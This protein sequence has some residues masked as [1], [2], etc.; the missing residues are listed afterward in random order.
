VRPIKP[1]TA[2]V[3]TTANAFSLPVRVYYEDT[4]SGGIVYYA[5]Y[6]KFM[7]RA[8]TEFLRELGFEQDHLRLHSKR[9]FVVKSA[10]VNY[11]QPAAFNALLEVTASVSDLR[12]ASVTFAQQIRLMQQAPQ[13]IEP[14][15]SESSGL[16]GQLICEG[17]VR[18]ACI[19]SDTHKPVPIP[20]QIKEAFASER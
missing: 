15:K 19:D 8:R 6:L 5:N 4:D 12:R 10:S 7:E 18:L 2:P 20:A 11:V 16:P 17:S 3:V 14:G 13:L 9:Q 1:I